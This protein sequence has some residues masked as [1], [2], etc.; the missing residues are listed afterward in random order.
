MS[1]VER[2]LKKIQESRGAQAPAEQSP[3]AS[4]PPRRRSAPA[5]AQPSQPPPSVTPSV[6]IDYEALRAKRLLPPPEQERVIAHQYRHI[7]RPIIAKALGRN[8][9]RV[10]NG[11]LIMVASALPNEGKTFSSI[12]L[13]LSM[14]MERDV[15]VL[16]VD[17]DV[18]K[19]HV[20][21]LFGIQ[22]KPGLLDALRDES[23]DVESLI[24]YTDMPGLATLPA[25]G[26][27]FNT[28]TELMASARMQAI[29]EQLIA[30]VPNRLVLFDSP[31]LL[32]TTEARVLAG[33]VGQVTMVVRA[34][35]TPRQAV[36]QALDF[37]GE[38]KQVGLI[39][40][41]STEDLGT[42]YYDYYGQG[43]GDGS[44]AS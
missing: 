27:P 39:L 1:L 7:K 42:G 37:I 28:A 26:G 16:L 12:N 23:V 34:G 10:P 35:E 29:V 25:G 30:K 31:P 11:Q 32:L 41:Q 9:E 36:L 19:R 2:A 13:A 15:S 22:N 17:A 44:S 24:Q 3:V 6:H 38:E 8:G 14:A 40:N 20:S 33:V 18:A 43:S 4:P 5:V 21:G